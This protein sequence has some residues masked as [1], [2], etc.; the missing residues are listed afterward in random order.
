VVSAELGI[1]RAEAVITGFPDWELC[2]FFSIDAAL[3]AKFNDATRIL[4]EKASL[5][6]EWKRSGKNTRYTVTRGEA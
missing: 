2:E 3:V 5:E 6:W 4:A 1:D